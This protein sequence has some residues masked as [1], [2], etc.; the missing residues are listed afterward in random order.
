MLKIT[1]IIA[2]EMQIQLRFLDRILRFHFKIFMFTSPILCLPLRNV[3][4][5]ENLTVYINLNW[6]IGRKI[7]YILFVIKRPNLSMIYTPVGLT[8]NMSMIEKLIYRVRH[9]PGP[10]DL[11]PNALTTAPSRHATYMT[12]W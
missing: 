9:E 1:N 10:P 5:S 7:G 12:H 2:I 11:Q 6:N 8:G 3:S 4:D